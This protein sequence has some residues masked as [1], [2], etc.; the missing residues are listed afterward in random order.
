V[1]TAISRQLSSAGFSVIDET[2]RN[3][4]K[5]DASTAS[6]LKGDAKS[7][8][9]LGS[10]FDIDILITGQAKADYVDKDDYGGV[11]LYRSRGRMDARA[12]YTDTGEVI[13]ATS[14][15]ADGLDQTKSLSAEAGLNKVGA[16]VGAIFAE[17]LLV[18]PAD[19]MP[20]LYVKITGFK[21]IMAAKRLEDSMRDLPGVTQLKRRRYTN[22]VLELNVYIKSDYKE[23]LPMLIESCPMGKKLGLTIESSS[24]TYMQAR[25]TKG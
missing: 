10:E 11:T 6:A 16:K 8:M 7:L 23:D 25:L 12:Y 15:S 22:G 24:K 14:A 1:E 2:K 17:D 3:R 5:S 9:E 4:L 19:M 21:G 13:S 20:F 18:A